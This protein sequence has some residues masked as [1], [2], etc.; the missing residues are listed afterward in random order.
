MND[1]REESQVETW[2]KS[3]KQSRNNLG[4][5][6]DTVS[7]IMCERIPEHSPE[8]ISGGIKSEIVTELKIKNWR[9]P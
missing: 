2:E 7:G 6:F 5:I 9:N 4:R 1:P 8:R 3:I